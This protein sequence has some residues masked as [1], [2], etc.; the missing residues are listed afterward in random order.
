MKRELVV[1]AG[2]RERELCPMSVSLDV[3]KTKIR[4]LRLS[5]GDVEVPCQWS[6]SDGTL[7]VSWILDKLGVNQ[8]KTYELSTEVP[9]AGI[10]GVKLTEVPGKHVEVE[11]EG[12]A[13]TADISVLDQF[14]NDHWIK[15]VGFPYR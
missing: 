1:S 7:T 8:C 13:F 12:E 4:D 9:A 2:V 6:L 3:G 14:G 11:I 15:G 5:E 10:K